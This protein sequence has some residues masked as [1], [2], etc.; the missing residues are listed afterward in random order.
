MTITRCQHLD[1]S[2]VGIIK[3]FKT[4]IITKFHEVKIKVK[5][6]EMNGKRDVLN[7]EILEVKNTLILGRLISRIEMTEKIIGKYEDKSI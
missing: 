2:D 5:K 1:D 6:H 3:D 7:R 4:A